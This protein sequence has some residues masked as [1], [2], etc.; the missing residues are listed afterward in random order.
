[1]HEKRQNYVRESLRVL[2]M[3]T[4]P[5]ILKPMFKGYFG[6]LSASYQRSITPCSYYKSRLSIEPITRAPYLSYYK[7]SF[8]T[9]STTDWL[10][11]TTYTH[12]IDI[13]GKAW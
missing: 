2:V 9:T 4:K 5:N 1:M 11:N 3:M 13:I 12:C 7:L 10:I 6:L 8:Q